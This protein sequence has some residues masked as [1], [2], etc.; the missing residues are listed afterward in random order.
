MNAREARTMKTTPLTRTLL[1]LLAAAILLL[2]FL[3]AAE[4]ATKE[5]RKEWPARPGLVVHLE[6]L[7]GKVTLEGTAGGAVELVATLHAENPADLDLLS[8]EA[9]ASGDRVE[10]AALYPVEKY[11]VFRYRDGDDSL[12]FGM[13]STSTTYRGRRVKVVSGALSRGIALWV[14]FRLRL[15]SGT[16]A[17]VR[18]EDVP[19][20]Q[21]IGRL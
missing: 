9:S 14:D 13:S 19:G 4:P 5:I 20:W 3:A 2:P 17:D 15:P 8:I 12:V 7:A 1:L 10:V 6:N 11:D 18:N 21:G 16:G